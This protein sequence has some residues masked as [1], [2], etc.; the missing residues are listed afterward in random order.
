MTTS[1][2]YFRPRSSVSETV[3]E[4]FALR[5]QHRQEAIDKK[6]V[7]DGYESI[8]DTSEEKKAE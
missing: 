1:A 6:V 4:L 5:A 8:E 2:A 3:D 7:M